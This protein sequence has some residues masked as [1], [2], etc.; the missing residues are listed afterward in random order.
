MDKPIWHVL[1]A[2]SIGCLWAASLCRKKEPVRLLVRN[3]RYRKLPNPEHVELSLSYQKENSHYRVP[4]S[5]AGEL[6]EPVARLIVCTKAQDAM[7]AV[8]A[9]A[10]NLT[11]DCKI[12]LLQNGMGSQQAIAE[13]FPKLS[14]WAGSATD[15]AYLNQAYDVCHAG[16]GMTTIG[17][18][19][20]TCAPEDFEPLL[21]KFRLDVQRVDDI[22]QVLWKKLAINCCINGLTALFDCHNGELLDNG[23]REQW[24]D[25]LAGEVNTVLSATSKPIKNLVESVH[26]I[27]QITA[28]N[29]SS[30]CHDARKGRGT[31]LAYIN[32]YL[33]QQA[34]VHGISVPTHENLMAALAKQGI[35]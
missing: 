8:K 22:E 10:R 5:C 2:G 17:P 12:L 3:E 32:H 9:I 4:I 34:A 18:L 31:E 29:I 23:E 1:G 21:K 27:C 11:D 14:V 28:D 30:T 35:Y 26:H 19:T 16:K 13:A 25:Q 33:I 7:T 15:G 6:S 24:L 20:P